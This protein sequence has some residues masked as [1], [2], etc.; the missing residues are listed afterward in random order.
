MRGER[1]GSFFKSDCLVFL[2]T[3]LREWPKTCEYPEAVRISLIQPIRVFLRAILDL[4]AEEILGERSLDAK[5]WYLAVKKKRGMFH[6]GKR[7]LNVMFIHQLNDEFADS[8]SHISLRMTRSAWTTPDQRVCWLKCGDL[9]LVFK[10]HVDNARLVLRRRDVMFDA[11]QVWMP[12][13]RGR[14]VDAGGVVVTEKGE[15]ASLGG[16]DSGLAR[17]LDYLRCLMLKSEKKNGMF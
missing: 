12:Y 16:R 11:H 13:V 9:I 10:S 6:F 5:N 1:A 15:G 14:I 8:L 3:V 17:N 4:Q 7:L 2:G